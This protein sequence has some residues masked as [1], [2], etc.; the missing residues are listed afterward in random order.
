MIFPV[1]SIGYDAFSGCSGLTSVTIP[2]SVK[3]I[4]YDAFS[5][6]RGLTSVTIGNSVTS[7]GNWAFDGCENLATVVSLIEK[8]FGIYGNN[9]NSNRTF[10]QNTFMNGTLYV[11]TGTKDAYKATAGW[12][13]FVFI[14]EGTGGND[15]VTPETKQCEKPTISYQNGK[16]TFSSETEG[17]TCVS[18][19]TDADMG[20][21]TTNEVQLGVT[22][23]ISVYAAKAG[24]EDSET[25]TATLCWI[26]V[27]P[28]TEG[29]GTEVA[30]VRAR[31]VLIQS[32]NGVLSISGAEPGQS[33][34]CFSLSGVQ[35]ASA[36]T[37]DDTTRVDTNLRSSEAVIVRI[38]DKS[39]KVL[40]K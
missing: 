13:D 1:T 32:Q 14:E 25:V 3:T 37:A 4:G 18:S 12:K 30:A 26:D 2:N 23:S 31:T 34:R 38:G 40:V 24:Y 5:G 33:V 8:P 27:E 17:A 11:P 22:Y 19:I 9:S 7:I 10:S 21:Y 29:I 35:L 15:P 39:I 36:T 16:L 6:C 20:T 28:K